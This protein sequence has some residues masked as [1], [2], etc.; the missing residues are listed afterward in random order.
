M[1]R[2]I[3][4]FLVLTILNCTTA[5]AGQQGLEAELAEARLPTTLYGSSTVNDGVDTVYIFGG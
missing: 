4:I 1:K 5:S 2:A 3:I